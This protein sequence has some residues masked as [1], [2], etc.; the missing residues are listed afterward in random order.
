[1]KQNAS[2]MSSHRVQQLDD[3]DPFEGFLLI[4]HAVF[5]HPFG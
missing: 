1:M 5:Q 2:E 3:R 4:K